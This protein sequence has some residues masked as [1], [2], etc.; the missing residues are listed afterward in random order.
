MILLIYSL[1]QLT[2]A[3]GL[4]KKGRSKNWDLFLNVH[5]TR[6]ESDEEYRCWKDII[7]PGGNKE[8]Q[9]DIPAIDLT[10]MCLDCLRNCLPNKLEF[11]YCYRSHSIMHLGGFAKFI[12]QYPK[13]LTSCV[14][15]IVQKGWSEYK[16]E[17]LKEWVK[18]DFDQKVI[19]SLCAQGAA[20]IR[21]GTI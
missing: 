8:A 2:A 11:L 4:D 5:G 3:C 17:Y 16:K 19:Q 13:I 1:H 20:T 15:R 7:Y 10:L 14:E 21:W 12:K 9:E 18:L 6:I